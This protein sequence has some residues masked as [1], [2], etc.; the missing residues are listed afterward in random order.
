MTPL[1][2]PPTMAKP[3]SADPAAAPR[4][5]PSP[6]LELT[7]EEFRRLGHELVDRIGEML[8]AMPA[9]RVT[10]G[11]PPRVV[12]SALGGNGLPARGTAAAE[13]LAEATDLLF[14]HSL[15]NGHPRFW[16]YITGSAAPLGMLGDLLAASVN[17][18][19]GASI[20]SPMATEIELQAV[21]WIADL[22]GCPAGTGGL[23]VSGGNMA[24]IVGLL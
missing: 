16:G 24:N 7:P 13:L 6:T 22:V 14:A 3:V 12:R 9:G 8:A 15:H 21:R 4:L 20:L 19:V 1:P 18:N 5:A 23:L 11:E 17:P 10:P 2:L